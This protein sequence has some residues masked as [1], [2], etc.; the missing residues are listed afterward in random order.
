MNME[1]NQFSNN[2][3]NRFES[4][5]NEIYKL[6]RVV[7]HDTRYLNYDEKQFVIEI[8]LSYLIFALNIRVYSVSELQVFL[9]QLAKYIQ[10]NLEREI[11]PSD[12]RNVVPGLD[13]SRQK[14]S[15]LNSIVEN[16]TEVVTT[17]KLLESQKPASFNSKETSPLEN[18]NER[19]LIERYKDDIAGF[20]VGSDRAFDKAVTSFVNKLMAVILETQ[21][22][23]YQQNFLQ[24]VLLSAGYA[25]RTHPSKK[26]ELISN[27]HKKG[28]FVSDCKKMYINELLKTS[29]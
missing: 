3:S 5:I 10:S 16:K 20:L 2:N 4:S 25:R 8:Y 7:I 19:L 6:L 22:S 21:R 13:L 9:Y 27:Y 14:H 26:Y 29:Q 11:G 15:C 23:P 12:E 1:I 28:L 17:Y 24:K 18:P